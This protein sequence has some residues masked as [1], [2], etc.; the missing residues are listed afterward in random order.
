MEY[1]YPFS[2]FPNGWFQIAYSDELQP[3]DVIPVHAVG[4]HLVLFR[5][6][7]G[8]PNVLD[9]YCPHLGAHLGYGGLI[10]GEVIR[11]DEPRAGG[12]R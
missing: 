8:A 1:R 11:V 6:E 12:G 10:E 5:T 3:G 9:A 2:P 4:K 7:S